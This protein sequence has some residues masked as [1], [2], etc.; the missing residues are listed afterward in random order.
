MA[1]TNIQFQPTPSSTRPTTKCQKVS[2][3]SD[4]RAQ[5]AVSTAPAIIMRRMPN[6][7]TRR[8]VKKPGANMATACHWMTLAEAPTPKPHSIISSGVAVM[9]RFIEP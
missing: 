6:R 1:E 3:S 7:P 5:Q 4:T 9:I 2:P 8:P